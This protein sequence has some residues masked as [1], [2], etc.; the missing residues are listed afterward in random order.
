[1]RVARAR[2]ILAARVPTEG[3]PS[4]PTARETSRGDIRSSVDRYAHWSSWGSIVAKSR[5]TVVPRRR[6]VPC[7][8]AAIRLPKPPTGRTSWLG[9]SRS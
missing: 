9:N 8:G 4:R 3:S 2:E 5:N 7:S 1:M 6:H